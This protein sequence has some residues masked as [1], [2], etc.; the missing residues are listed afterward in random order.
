V[1]TT[2]KVI[3][4]VVSAPGA[5]SW[6]SAQTVKTWSTPVTNTIASVG[7][8]NA[9]IIN[10]WTGGC[11]DQVRGELLLVANGGHGDYSGNEVYALALR[12]AS[13]SWVRL[14]NP[15]AATG[16]TDASNSQGNYGDGR[17]RPVHGWNQTT[18]ANGRAWVCGMG[19]MYLS[20]NN[21][22]A[23][24][25]FNRDAVGSGPFPVA[26]APWT[27][28]GLAHTDTGNMI[29]DGGVAAY[30]RVSGLVWAVPGI[31]TS[32]DGRA[33][34][35]VNATSGAITRYA[36]GT[37]APAGGHWAA[38]AYDTSPRVMIIGTKQ[39]PIRVINLETQTISDAI[40]SGSPSGA[41]EYCGAHYHQPSRAVLVYN[42]DFGTT[43]RKLKIPANP[44]TG[45]YVWSAVTAAT[46]G[47][48]PPGTLDANFRGVWNKFQLIEDMGN[49]QGALVTVHR[50]TGATYVYKL[51]VGELT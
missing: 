43:I 23:V 14:T 11:A 15:S 2:D 4:F 33:A 24:W 38:I 9:G 30:D 40:V 35:S 26:N 34:F 50:V 42:T 25:S 28:H 13:P 44:I 19:G 5:P 32:S 49:G 18:F 45:T 1:A 20:G 17:M 6:F 36:M 7:S 12:A 3:R 37:N 16:G 47:A 21:S 29:M 22:S 41:V 27:Y 48:S 10:P 8:G 46:G 31:G 51:P 39:G